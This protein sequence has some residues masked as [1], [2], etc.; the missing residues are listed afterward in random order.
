MKTAKKRKEKGGNDAPVGAAAGA[1]ADR[2][3]CRGVTAWRLQ[4]GRSVFSSGSQRD[5]TMSCFLV[6]NVYVFPATSCFVFSRSAQTWPLP[7]LR[8]YL[9]LRK[10]AERHFFGLSSA[11]RRRFGAIYLKPS[12]LRSHVGS[13]SPKPSCRQEEGRRRRET[14]RKKNSINLYGENSGHKAAEML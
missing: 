1:N 2:S 8:P 12:A 4:E 7:A 13:K 3:D 9:T 6:H 14:D 11:S 5:T 10:T